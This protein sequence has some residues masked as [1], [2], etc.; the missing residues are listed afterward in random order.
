MERLVLGGTLAL[1]ELRK[2]RVTAPPI[3]TVRFCDARPNVQAPLLRA[4]PEVTQDL[5]RS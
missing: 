4:L 3:Q 2:V 1:E 5:K